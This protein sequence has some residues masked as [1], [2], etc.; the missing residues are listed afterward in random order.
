M[1]EYTEICKSIL[2]YTRIYWDV[3]V[4]WDLQEYTEM[5]KSILG[6][7]RV[8]WDV[9]EYTKIYRPVICVDCIL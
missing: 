3:Q 2:E 1:Q 5:Y 9:Q 6:C 4:Y 7:T 8:Y